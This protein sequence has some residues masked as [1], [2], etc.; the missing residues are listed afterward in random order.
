LGALLGAFPSVSRR[1]GNFLKAK[2]IF[3]MSYSFS[4]KASTKQA[5]ADAV[6]DE[7]GKV[8]AS[9]PAHAADAEQAGTAVESF[10]DLLQDDDTRDYLASV[11]GSLYTTEQ[12]CQQAS[13]SINVGMVDRE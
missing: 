4:A 5:L 3:A 9:Q 10:A 1:G 6:V 8:V 11:S 12:G 7:L 2:E 13:I